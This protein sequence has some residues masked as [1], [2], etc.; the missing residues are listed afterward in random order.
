VIS[1][2]VS[3][4]LGWVVLKLLL[5]RLRKPIHIEPTP[6]PLICIAPARHPQ[7]RECADGVVRFI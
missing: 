5:P 1:L 2:F 6:S 3:I 4:F 7:Q